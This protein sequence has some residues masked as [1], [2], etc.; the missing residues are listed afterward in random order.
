[1]LTDEQRT[2][3]KSIR[4]K[5][6]NDADV[7][8]A[9]EAVKD[10]ITPEERELAVEEYRATVHKKMSSEDRAFLEELRKSRMQPQQRPTQIPGGSGGERF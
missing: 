7:K 3:V 9:R 10:A 5:Y 2:R 1:M 8:A 6:K 4:E